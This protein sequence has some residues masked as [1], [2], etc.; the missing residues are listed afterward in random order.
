MILHSLWKDV[1]WA[2][3]SS[4]GNDL[5]SGAHTVNMGKYRNLK[6]HHKIDKCLLNT[7]HYT[8]VLKEIEDSFHIG[9]VW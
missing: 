5:I 2:P 4:G 3:Y 6:T 9:A 1:N 8:K 7:N